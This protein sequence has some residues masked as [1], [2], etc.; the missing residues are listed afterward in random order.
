MVVMAPVVSE[1]ELLVAPTL[2]A[3]PLACP[4]SGTPTRGGSHDPTQS[5]R[6]LWPCKW[7][8]WRSHTFQRTARGWGCLSTASDRPRR[9]NRTPLPVA[10]LVR[11]HDQRL[12]IGRLEPQYFPADHVAAQRAGG[13]VLRLKASDVEALIVPADQ[14][15]NW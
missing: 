1:A 15:R 5:C 4:R 8:R 13:K 14:C 7:P 9:G 6:E 12:D 2:L 11:G 3:R 10:A